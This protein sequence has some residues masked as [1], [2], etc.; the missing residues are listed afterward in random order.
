MEDSVIIIVVILSNTYNEGIG[1]NYD[2]KYFIKKI[3]KPVLFS[4]DAGFM[5]TVFGCLGRK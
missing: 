4:C 3:H 1:E 2:E 5:F